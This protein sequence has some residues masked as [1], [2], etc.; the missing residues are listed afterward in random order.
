[1]FSNHIQ[2]KKFLHDHFKLLS[3]WE[4]KRESI[5]DKIKI[6][7]MVSGLVS[8]FNGMSTFAGYWKLKQPL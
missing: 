7:F 5:E 2:Q 8:L 6:R 1:M 3:Q 4:L